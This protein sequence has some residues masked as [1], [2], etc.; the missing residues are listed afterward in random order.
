MATKHCLKNI[1]TSEPIWTLSD[2]SQCFKPILCNDTKCSFE[3][4]V[5]YIVTMRIVGY[6]ASMV[7]LV[8]SIIILLRPK[9]RCPRN[10]VHINLFVAF[11]VR[12]IL[13]ILVDTYINEVTMPL[14]NQNLS[15][16]ITESKLLSKV[17]IN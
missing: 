15:T 5:K 17:I 3:H 14:N 10:F 6:A 2:Y 1:N 7:S 16:S 8:L 13:T 11:S 4:H 9:L 12:T